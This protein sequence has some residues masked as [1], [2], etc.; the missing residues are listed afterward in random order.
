MSTPSQSNVIIFGP[1]TRIDSPSKFSVYC[2][3]T[4]FFMSG[5]DVRINFLE[6]VPPQEGKPISVV[7][8]SIVMSPVHAKAFLHAF[9]NTLRQYEEQ[10]GEIDAQK[11]MDFQS[12]SAQGVN[13]TSR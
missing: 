3:G 9:S 6:N 1:P 13:P 5:W 11:V 2:N 12:A 4:E 10:F 7:H 8:G